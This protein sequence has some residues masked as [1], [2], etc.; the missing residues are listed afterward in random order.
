MAGH[1]LP[2]VRNENDF[3]K[4]RK[5]KVTSINKAD[6]FHMNPINALNMVS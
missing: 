5:P 1:K 4:G 2:W 6:I 3:T